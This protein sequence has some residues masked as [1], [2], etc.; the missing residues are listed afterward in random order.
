MGAVLRMQR[1]KSKNKIVAKPRESHLGNET[2]NG[3][4]IKMVALELGWNAAD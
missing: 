1:I 3:N 4:N 2:V